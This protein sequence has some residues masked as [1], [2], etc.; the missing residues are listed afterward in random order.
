MQDCHKPSIW[1][2][3]NTVSAKL[4]KT[5]NNKR[6]YVC[7]IISTYQLKPLSLAQ[8]LEACKWHIWDL[9]LSIWIL[10]CYVLKTGWMGLE[11]SYLDSV[12]RYHKI[13]HSFH[14]GLCSINYFYFIGF[15]KMLQ[16][17]L[18]SNH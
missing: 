3:K 4:N 15:L 2:K 6:R 7:A 1:K 10:K 11:R 16:V 9:K 13:F 14:N 17:C 5:K 18:R 8:D 12:T